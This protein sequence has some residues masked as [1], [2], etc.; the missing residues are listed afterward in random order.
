MAW[1]LLLFTILSSFGTSMQQL[2]SLKNSESV[3]V[4]GTIT[5]SC[6][7]SGG[8]IHDNNYLRWLQQKPGKVLRLLVATS[9]MRPS[10]VPARFTGTTSG[11]TMSL[12]IAGTLGEDEATY[13]CA[14]WTG[15]GYT[16]L[17]SDG[18]VKQKLSD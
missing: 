2:Q 5:M 14:V 18:E 13:Y 1:I 7:Y 17:D 10:G 8:T 4:G 11:N 16:V 3:A 15:S 9:N 6:S 12:T